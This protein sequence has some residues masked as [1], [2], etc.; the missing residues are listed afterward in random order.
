MTSW[1]RLLIALSTGAC[2]VSCGDCGDGSGSSNGP[3]SEANARNASTGP[4]SSSGGAAVLPFAECAGADAADPLVAAACFG[5]PDAPDLDN[6]LAVIEHA[7]VE[8]EGIPAV[9]LRLTF[10]PSF[11]DN[12]YGANGIGWEGERDGVRP[13]D[14]LVG[15]DH[16]QFVALDATGEVI[17]ELK[18]DYLGEVDTAD[19]GYASKGVADKDGEVIIGEESDVL[20]WTT[21]MD[22]NL[23]ERG[24]CDYLEDSPATDENCTR[25]P[26]APNWDFRVVYEIWLRRSAFEPNGF[27]TAHMTFVHASPAKG[28][29]NTVEIVR[30]DCPC[31]TQEHE[32]RDFPSSGTNNSTNNT[33]N[34]NNVVPE[35]SG[36]PG[37]PCTVDDDCAT[38]S[39]CFQGTCLSV[40]L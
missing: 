30:Q 12:T 13:F 40:I 1:T 23:N 29:E 7:Y 34:N 32:C 2:L 18:L 3:N 16:S 22:R 19:C 21:S 10:D 25:N 37:D 17:F 6:P 9:Y 15:S 14:K 35:P 4:N 33:P 8:W 31:P 36:K 24:Y 26:D 20:H 28:G 38:N 39:F 27:G 11:V 5:D